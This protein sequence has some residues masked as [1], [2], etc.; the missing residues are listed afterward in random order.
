MATAF[1]FSTGCSLFGGGGLEHADG[2]SA[3]APSGWK[4]QEKGDSD[5]AYRTP[6]G[7]VATLTSSCDSE[8]NTTQLESLTRHLL[9]GAR[10]IEF[11]S[12]KNMP[13]NGTDGLY[14]QLSATYGKVPFKLLVFVWPHEN[15]VFDFT[16]LNPKAISE[17]DQTE[18][19]EFIKS[20]N[21]G[22]K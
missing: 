15:C 17:K 9:F 2:F 10:N 4:A 20:F 7:S 8:I 11:E 6:Q 18:F 1:L 5:Y 21:Y 14:S 16:L 22:K 13:I 19:L 3:L 12:R